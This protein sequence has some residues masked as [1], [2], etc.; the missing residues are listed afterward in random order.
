LLLSAARAQLFNQVLA[1]R[2][3]AAS[4]DR[5]LAGEVLSLA[6]S[7]RQ[8]LHDPDDASIDERLARLDIHPTGPLC[9]RASRALQPLAEA[10]EL[11]DGVLRA[12]GDWIA[13]LERFG[14]DADRRALRLVV[15]DV[16]WGWQGDRLTLG[17]VLPAGAFA[18]AVLRE[19]I[20]P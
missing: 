13:G 6:G 5:A 1:A 2:V 3:A 10:R 4:W 16:T 11:E 15:E 14:L 7:Q 19:L 9:G 17:F 12:S 8:F 20:T 18:T